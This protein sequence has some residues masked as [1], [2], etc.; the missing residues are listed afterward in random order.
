VVVDGKDEEMGGERVR[1]RVCGGGG[2]VDEDKA[3]GPRSGSKG[4]EE[5]E[6]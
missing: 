2:G 3:R 1:I 6:E 5:G 4:E